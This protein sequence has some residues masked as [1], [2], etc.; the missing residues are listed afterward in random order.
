MTNMHCLQHTK[1]SNNCQEKDKQPP[2]KWAEDTNRY[3]TEDQILKSNEHRTYSTS[4]GQGNVTLQQDLLSHPLD[5]Q[6]ENN[7]YAKGDAGE[8]A[9]T[10]C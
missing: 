7:L 4:D 6:K 3:I 2:G 9:P 8:R 10:L 5:Q 1:S